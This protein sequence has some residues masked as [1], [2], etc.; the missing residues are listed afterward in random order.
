MHSA[1]K[2]NKQGDNIQPWC[3]PF[4][5]WNQSVVPCPVL[6]VASWPAYR[7]LKRQVR[8]AGIPISFR[9]F[10][11]LLTVCHGL[12]QFVDSVTWAGSKWLAPIQ[13]WN[14]ISSKVKWLTE[15]YTSS[16]PWSHREIQVCC[17]SV[18]QSCPTVCNPMNGSMPHFL[19]F[20]ISQ[21]LLK[22]M[23]IESVMPSNHLILCRPL[24]LLPSIFPGIRV[25]SNEPA[26]Y[27][28]ITRYGKYALRWQSPPPWV[29]VQSPPLWLA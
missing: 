13:R 9:I 4:P 24:L 8:W 5:I 22:L 7:F 18:A 19:S 28:L 10:H 2:L 20:T 25:F 3:T 26:L 1:C 23:P 27:H 17:C 12:S 14:E 15:R 11:S 29:L 21:S 16:K 6:T